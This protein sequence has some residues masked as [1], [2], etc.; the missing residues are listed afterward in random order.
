VIFPLSKKFLF[1][2]IVRLKP[3]TDE[4]SDTK[5]LVEKIN[6]KDMN[7]VTLFLQASF[8]G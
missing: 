5:T 1:E 7:P 2:T 4:G 3:S 8:L 6:L